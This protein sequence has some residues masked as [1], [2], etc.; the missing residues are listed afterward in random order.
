MQEQWGICLL[1]DQFALLTAQMAFLAEIFT[2]S[3]N[4]VSEWVNFSEHR[5]PE[6][7]QDLQNLIDTWMTLSMFWLL[8]DKYFQN[9]HPCTKDNP[10]WKKGEDLLARRVVHIFSPS[11]WKWEGLASLW[12]WSQPGLYTEIQDKQGYTVKP[13]LENKQTRE[14]KRDGLIYVSLSVVYV[15]QEY[16]FACAGHKRGI[17]ALQLELQVEKKPT[18]WMSKFWQRSYWFQLLTCL[19]SHT[20]PMLVS[21]HSQHTGTLVLGTSLQVHSL[22][23][24]TKYFRRIYGRRFHYLKFPK[25]LNNDDVA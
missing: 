18:I 12:I 13:C 3:Y 7:F 21:L 9:A 15:H 8:P 16:L 17:H 6:I 25:V 23:K 2:P 14:K 22:H 1:C 19:S 24:I 4:S 20:N 10:L 11:T 5:M